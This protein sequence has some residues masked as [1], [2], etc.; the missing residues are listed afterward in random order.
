MILIVDDDPDL[1]ENCSMILACHGY[2]ASV[3][4]SA[5]EAL[6]RVAQERP[7]L[8]ISD[9]CMP[10]MGGLELSKQLKGLPANEQFPIVLMSG[11]LQC[12]EA[13]GPGYDGF[14]RKPFM[15]EEL[16]G[17]VRAPLD[18]HAAAPDLAPLAA[19]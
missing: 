7:A 12:E 5:E 3:V 15:A 4:S 9:C 11:S 16:V 19:H 1:A 17:K 10:G 6:A 14:L 2:E 13:G 18:Q 8:L